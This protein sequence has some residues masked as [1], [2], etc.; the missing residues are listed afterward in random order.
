MEKTKLIENLKEHNLYYETNNIFY[1]AVLPTSIIDYAAIA[2][3][4]PFGNLLSQTNFV[5]NGNNNGIT[6]IPCN[7]VTNLPI[8][9]KA[10]LINKEAIS[11]LVISNGN[12][13]FNKIT[14][15]SN[16]KEIISL[17]VSK[18][19]EPETKSA[20]LTIFT[21]YYV[22]NKELI[23]KSKESSPLK[24]RIIYIILIV[25]SVLVLYGSLTSKEYFV[26]SCAFISLIC[27]L[28]LI[29]KSFSSKK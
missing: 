4:G 29:F 1:A 2:A 20:L 26:S 16:N 24:K 9:E 14:I 7:K 19:I 6:L 22:E 10:I 27:L 18:N 25:L 8:Y 13:G 5:V 28:G 12:L 17:Q 15:F 3:F 21:M 23:Q 11:K